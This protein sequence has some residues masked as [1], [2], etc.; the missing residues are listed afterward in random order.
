MEGGKYGGVEE[1][2]CY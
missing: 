2:A 1:S